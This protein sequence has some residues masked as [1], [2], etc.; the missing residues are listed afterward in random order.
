MLSSIYTWDLKSTSGAFLPELDRQWA[1]RSIL[2]QTPSPEGLELT[3]MKTKDKGKQIILGEEPIQ[4][5][6]PVRC[7]VARSSVL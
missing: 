6:K 4:E 1:C 7:K 3:G 2:L 5:R